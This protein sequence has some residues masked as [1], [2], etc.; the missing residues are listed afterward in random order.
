MTD[1]AFALEK[2]ALATLKAA[3]SIRALAGNRV[4]D[5]VPFEAGFPYIEMGDSQIVPD[6]A[7]GFE[8]S[9]EVYLTI[10]AWSRKPGR[11]QARKLCGAIVD[12]LDGTDLNLGS[13]L[14]LALIRY[15]GTRYLQDGD[16]LTSHGV[17]AFRALIDPA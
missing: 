16:G 2:A 10:H 11:P 8:R 1:P 6:P 12:A 5:V 9:T 14:E 3:T 13:D 7:D 15:D 17:V 4:F